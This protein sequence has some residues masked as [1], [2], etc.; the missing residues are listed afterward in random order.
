MV[1][2]DTS[3]VRLL[4]KLS[5]HYFGFNTDSGIVYG[6]KA[7]SM[8]K[9]IDWGT[10]I[11][12]S[13]NYLGTNYAVRGN[14][15]R[16]L[17]NFY[18]SLSEYTRIGDEQ[19]IA[20]IT[21][22]LG[23][24]FRIRK[25]FDKAEDYV[26][27]AIELNT[28]LN[29]KLDL[30]KN[31]NNLG[32]I[33]YEKGNYTRSDSCYRKALILADGI[34]NQRLAAEVLINM[35]ELRMKMKD[36]CGA[37]NYAIKAKN[38]SEQLSIP[39]DGA[40][41]NSYVGEIYLKI[42]VEGI[43]SSGKC[44]YI[45]DNEK[46]NLVSATKYLLRSLDLLNTVQD[47]SLL[48]E[49]C[50]LLSQTYEKLG[51]D[52]TALKYFKQFSIVKDSIESKDANV[53]LA[54]IEKNREVVLRDNKIK[55]QSLEIE[56]QHAQIRFQIL[57]FLLIILFITLLF[58]F[59][60]KKIT[61]SRLRASEERY[62]SIFENLQDVFYQ[63]DLSGII[64]DISPSIARF[65]DYNREEV[66]GTP[67]YNFYTNLND[68][69]LFLREIMRTGELRDWELKFKTKTKEIWVSV[70][71]RIIAGPDG[72]PRHIN[73]ALRDITKRKQVEAELEESREKYRGF[74][75]SAFEAIFF[76]EDGICIEQNGAAAKMFGYTSEEAIGMS[77]TDWFVKED[78]RIVQENMNRCVEERYEATALR[79]DGSIFPCLLQVRMMNYKGRNVRVTSLSDI[80][81]LKNTEKQ[82]ELLSRA[83]EKSPVTVLITDKRGKIE[84][85][86]PHFATVTGYSLEETL[87]QNPRILKSGEKSKEYYKELW[88]TIL[89][90][91]NWFGEFRNRKKNGELY[92]ENVVISPII[93]PDGRISH[94]VAVKADI[95]EKNKMVEDLIKAKEKA[96]ES[97]NLKTAFLNNISHEIRTPFN[98]ILG[99]LTLLQFDD[100]TSEERNEYIGLITKSADRLMN[101]INEI[102]EISQ[103]QTGQIAIV[104]TEF[105][106]KKLTREIAERF[107][108]HS[109]S[110][111]LKFII[112]NNIPVNY[113]IIRTDYSKLVTILSHLISNA[114][115]F[116]KAGLV[117]FDMSIN[118]DLLEFKVTDTGIG[119]APIKQAKIF[120]R[121]MQADT[122][123]TRRFEGSG[124]GL[125]IS[126]A[127]AGMLGGQIWLRSEEGKGSL[128]CL[129][130]PSKEIVVRGVEN[131]VVNHNEI[132]GDPIEGLNILIAE[133]DE[134]SAVLLKI[135]I[136]ALTNNISIVTNGLDAVEIC[137]NHP[138]MDLILMDMKM[139]G[140]DGYEATRQIRKFNQNIIIIA[141][142]AF[143]LSGDREE[144]I[145]AGCNDYIAKPIKK[146]QL[147][148]IIQKY[149][150]LKS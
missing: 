100:I 119:I 101:T 145:D 85:V 54:N 29:T 69:E 128:F 142:T 103:I 56:H 89:S 127:Y 51:D 92:D 80:T 71:A 126:Q 7:L 122:S 1:L 19:G 23:N 30:A 24:F 118:G 131:N 3:K 123:N 40:V 32:I 44:R 4:G 108:M 121:F 125:S 110:E 31:Y 35:S 64:T 5:F 94:F 41:Y 20:F 26:L 97:D 57:L 120:E 150:K 77:G 99:F 95:T 133:D 138:E 6:E 73:G 114:I 52:K 116:T 33:S 117:E 130:I 36:F 146:E 124:L 147:I 49:T 87:G 83:I 105:S 93:D 102:V 15:P 53:K 16:A 68:R 45:S 22:N 106:V 98:G 46:D 50:H 129:S 141:Q 79:K 59:Y 63:I 88:D 144:S 104:F 134:Q 136:K 48:S 109:G 43:K 149:F 61:A 28:K 113:E 74:S 135:T 91:N 112:R 2:D 81:L 14:F 10:G 55:I 70:N 42:V 39:Y 11:A 107:E 34:D 78:R 115:K 62:R 58:Y 25:E 17:E 132:L 65:S 111:G 27:K 8:A 90:G 75:E 139:P 84:Y 96:E 13:Y 37:L 140:M 38:I 9:K 148:E 18:K 21:N 86:N 143:A 60:Y 12:F 137:R 76:F 72:Q 47:Q 82:L 67:V 66:L